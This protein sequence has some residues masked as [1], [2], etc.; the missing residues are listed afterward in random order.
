MTFVCWNRRG[1][2]PWTLMN[3]LI[4]RGSWQTW[5]YFALIDWKMR[6]CIFDNQFINIFLFVSK[7]IN[8]S[9]KTTAAPSLMEPLTRLVKSSEPLHCG[10]RKMGSPSILWKEIIRSSKNRFDLINF[11]KQKIRKGAE[12]ERICKGLDSKNRKLTSINS[13]CHKY[14]VAAQTTVF[15]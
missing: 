15:T 8:S 7:H 6:K 14:R 2:N 11:N 3:S 5:G 13:L 4:M 10:I 1:V 12:L 9:W